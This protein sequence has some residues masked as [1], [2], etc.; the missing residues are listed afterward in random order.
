MAE[1]GIILRNWGDKPR[2]S[3]CVRLTIGTDEEMKE[4]I[5]ELGKL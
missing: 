3:D 2:I 4:V 1:K 5:E